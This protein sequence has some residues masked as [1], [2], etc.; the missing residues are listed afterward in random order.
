MARA[1]GSEETIANPP[2]EMKTKLA[3]YMVDLERWQSAFN[4]PMKRLLKSGTEKDHIC[5][6]SLEYVLSLVHDHRT[7]LVV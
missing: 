1:V 3:K 4:Q 6:V 7:D 2:D 5:T